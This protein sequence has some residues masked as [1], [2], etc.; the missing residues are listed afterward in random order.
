M[1]APTPTVVSYEYDADVRT[2]TGWEPL[3]V[4]SISPSVDRDRVP[5]ASASLMLDPINRATFERLDPRVVAPSLTGQ[6]RWRIRQVDSAGNVI[7][8]LPRVGA[9]VG[10]Y[11]IMHIRSTTRTITGVRIDLDGRELLADDKLNIGANPVAAIAYTTTE[12]IEWLLGQVFGT[13]TITGHGA[14]V[15]VLAQKPWWPFVNV[16]DSYLSTIET[17]LNSHDC[18]LLDLWGTGWHVIERA[19]PP[20]YTGAPTVVKLGTFTTDAAHT[21]PVDV[22]PIVIDLEDTLSRDG[23]WADAVVVRGEARASEY[24]TTWQ[25]QAQQ[26]SH[27]RGKVITIDRGEP[28]GNLAESIASRTIIRGRDLRV[29]ARA[30]FDVL[31]GM[32][33]QIHMRG[34]ILSALISGVGWTPEN[35][36]MTIH[37]QS[38]VAA[39]DIDEAAKHAEQTVTP[40]YALATIRE[41]SSVIAPTLADAKTVK[42]RQDRSDAE[43]ASLGLIL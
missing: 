20:S 19:T 23:E 24:T 28:S 40:E 13:G 9:T 16:N 39:P 11:A 26:T 15:G 25:H 5:Y 7:G 32:E 35:G 31:P 43:M 36:T 27:T 38:A 1:T 33:L 6:V 8:Y 12:L 3:P 21:L 41:L 14:A 10:D 4:S 37:A 30:R 2:A 29:T 42:A 34:E 22:D 18:R 17:E